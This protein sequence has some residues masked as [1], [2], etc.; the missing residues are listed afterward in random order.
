VLAASAPAADLPEPLAP[1][2]GALMRVGVRPEFLDDGRLRIDLQGH[3]PFDTNSAE[4][5]ADSRLFLSS[6]AALLGTAPAVQIEVVG[7]TDAAGTPEHNLALSRRRA[8]AVSAYLA[9][10]GVSPAR[11]RSTGQGSAGAEPDGRGSSAGQRKIVIYLTHLP[12]GG[13]V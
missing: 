1:L 7:H 6:L 3:V 9:A 13:P 5:G 4:F 11:L 12:P 2:A 8:E 10:R